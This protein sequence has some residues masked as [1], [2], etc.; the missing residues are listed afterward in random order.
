MIISIY[1]PHKTLFNV[2][3]RCKIWGIFGIFSE[4]YNISEFR[5]L[6]RKLFSEN[7]VSEFKKNRNSDRKSEMF[8]IPVG[9]SE[10]KFS[11]SKSE[12]ATELLG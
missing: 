7:F 2:E 10:Q 5:F 8:L 4:M 6:F 3:N 1:F 11:E 12:G 9:I